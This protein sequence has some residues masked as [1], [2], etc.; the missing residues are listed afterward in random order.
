MNLV[1]PQKCTLRRVLKGSLRAA[2]TVG[3]AAADR[4]NSMLQRNMFERGARTGRKKRAVKSIPMP[5]YKK[6]LR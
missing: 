4:F 6:R 3:S 2:K 5:G 1:Y